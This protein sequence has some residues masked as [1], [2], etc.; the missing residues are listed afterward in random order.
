LRPRL[1]LKRSLHVESVMLYTVVS[2]TGSA[3]K[4]VSSGL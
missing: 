2:S 1:C 4:M 3:Q